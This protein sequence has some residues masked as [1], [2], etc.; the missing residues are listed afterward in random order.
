M[1]EFRQ[2]FVKLGLDPD[3]FCMG[4]FEGGKDY[5]VDPEN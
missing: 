5:P 3:D 4:C 2:V 1:A